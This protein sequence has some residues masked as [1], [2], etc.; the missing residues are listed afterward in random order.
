[1]TVAS[2]KSPDDAMVTKHFYGKDDATTVARK[3]TNVL[4]I[5]GGHKEI[6]TPHRPLRTKFFTRH[7]CAQSFAFSNVQCSTASQRRGKPRPLL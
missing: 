7:F 2:D 1:M 6:A 4:P 5:R 3:R